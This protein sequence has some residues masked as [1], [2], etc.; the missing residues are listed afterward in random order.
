M[1]KERK[2]QEKE[3]EKFITETRKKEIILEL[4]NLAQ[5]KAGIE[6]VN[7]DLKEIDLKIQILKDEYSL[8]NS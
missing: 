2:R 3:A 5:E 1:A 8:Y 7:G 6:L 4:G